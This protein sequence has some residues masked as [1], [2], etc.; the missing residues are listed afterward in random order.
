MAPRHRLL[1]LLNRILVVGATL[2]LVVMMVHIVL[3]VVLRVAFNRPIYGTFEIVEYWYLPVVA[4]LGLVAAQ[5][6]REHIQVT[7]FTDL[8]PA[9]QR[10]IL[11]GVALALTAALCLV[12]TV[13]SLQLGIEDA[14][15]RTTAGVTDIPAWPLQLAVPVAFLLLGLL[16]FAP[17]VEVAE[18]EEQAELAG[19][20]L[21][22][23]MD[24]VD[25]D[26]STARTEAVPAAAADARTTIADGPAP[27][28][29]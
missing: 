23:V 18:T 8:L 10:K 25:T 12:I 14:A 11:H 13:M 20:H 17:P 16:L 3:N 19:E 27:H 1:H 9:G 28:R 6:M 5:L 24:D 4:L 29:P 2:A 15:H 21:P 22:G 7:A 26:W